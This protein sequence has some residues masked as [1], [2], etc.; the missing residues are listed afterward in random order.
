MEPILSFKA[1]P[2]RARWHM[3]WIQ[4]APTPLQTDSIPFTAV[5]QIQ[6]TNRTPIHPSKKPASLSEVGGREVNAERRS[7]TTR[8]G[9]SLVGAPPP[10]SSVG[11][12]QEAN[13]TAHGTR[14]L[15]ISPTS[16]NG[17]SHLRPEAFPFP[18]RVTHS[19]AYK[20]TRLTAKLYT[21]R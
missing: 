21:A 16:E 12:D 8:E 17:P 13:P 19:K 3:K 7:T 20:K 4:V 6:E 2:S 18:R 9:L 5:S 11:N 10:Q 15:S 14:L 1:C